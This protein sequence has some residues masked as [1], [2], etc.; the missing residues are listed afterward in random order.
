MVLE[1]LLEDINV[2]SPPNGTDNHHITKLD[3]IHIKL[4]IKA[5]ITQELQKEK[6]Y[7]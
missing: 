5:M 6:T 4:L 7:L 2:V 3:V 1:E